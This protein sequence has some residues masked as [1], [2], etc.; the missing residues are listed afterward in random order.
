M[1]LGR[2]GPSLFGSESRALKGPSPN[3]IDVG[4]PGCD[5]NTRHIPFFLAPPPSGPVKL[6]RDPA[7]F[8]L[9]ASKGNVRFP[10]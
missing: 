2:P 8:K 3:L 10:E 7:L 9:W 5:R 4:A 1:P 6:Q